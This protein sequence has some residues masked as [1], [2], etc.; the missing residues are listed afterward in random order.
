M[1][2]TTNQVHALRLATQPNNPRGIITTMGSVKRSLIAAGYATGR[3]TVTITDAGRAAIAHH[4][5]NNLPTVERT[6]ENELIAREA[7][8]RARHEEQLTAEQADEPETGT[9]RQ[10]AA[11]IGRSLT[12]V[13]R[14]IKAGRLTARKVA[15]RWAIV[16]PTA[17]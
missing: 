9:A 10:V 8:E 7:E 1:Q 4:D 17:S 11:L 13:Y 14:W 5:N 12:T 3:G 6:R 16:L 15:G 2:L